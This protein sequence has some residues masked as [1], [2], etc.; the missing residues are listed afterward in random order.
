MGL[1]NFVPQTDVDGQR[2]PLKWTQ[3]RSVEDPTMAGWTFAYLVFSIDSSPA[4]MAG[5]MK[6]HRHIAEVDRLTRTSSL[7]HSRAT[8]CSRAGEGATGK[9]LA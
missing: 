9:M 7:V 5:M 4:A 2:L 6:D 3:E 8:P 1:H